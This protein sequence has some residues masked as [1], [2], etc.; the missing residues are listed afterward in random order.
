[1]SDPFSNDPFFSDSGFGS[2]GR[3][4]DMM[5][6]MEDNMRKQMAD[7]PRASDLGQG[8]FMKQTVHTQM[9]IGKD[10]KPI[11]E[12]YQTKAHGAIGGGN[13]LVDR[14]QIYENTG[15]GMHRAAHER[16][17][18]DQGR[19]IIKERI[20]DSQINNF[21]HF[22]NM[23][24]SDAG[25]FDQKWQEI[26]G[27]LG[28]QPNSNALEYGGGRQTYGQKPYD[29]GLGNARH[30]EARGLASTGVMDDDRHGHFIPT[31]A[32]RENQPVRLQQAER[33]QPTMPGRA[34]EPRQNPQTLAIGNGAQAARVQPARVA[35]NRGQVNNY[36]ASSK[37]K[38]PAK[39][40]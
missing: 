3:A 27:N 39:A 7:M 9:K 40:G 32:R 6:K 35:A 16:M 15:T 21:D 8:Q 4:D 29:R 25:H 24:A 23:G 14:Q 12:T 13:R 30:A 36:Q 33:L 31:H 26:A 17:I 38:G 5:R 1:M 10:G 34:S 18:N 2:F 20:G 37:P 28:F 19:K 22:K 11:K